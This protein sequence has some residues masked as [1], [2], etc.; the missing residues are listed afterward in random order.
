MTLALLFHTSFKTVFTCLLDPTRDPQEGKQAYDKD[1]CSLS[2]I[3]LAS[4]VAV[5]SVALLIF[6]V[7]LLR[8]RKKQRKGNLLSY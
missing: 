2:V 6:G 7:C 5:L 8:L 4:L 3:I 1:N